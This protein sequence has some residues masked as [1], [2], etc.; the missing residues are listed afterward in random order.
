M[1][2]IKF[3]FC[4]VAFFGIY[5]LNAQSKKYAIHTV[6]FYNFENLFDIIDDPNTN[7]DEWTP[8]GA[9]H[10]T[11][12]KYEQKLKNLSRVLSEIGTPENSTAPTL[13]G[14][15]EIENRGVLEDLIKQ[16]KIA[17][18]DYGIIHFDSPDQRGIDVALLYQKKYFRPTSFS[19]IP[20]LI[21]KNKSVL[22]ENNNEDLGDVEVKIDIKNRVFT[23]DQ[24][25]VTGFLDDEE[26]HIIVNHWPSRSG[27]EKASSPYREAAGKLNRKI[28]D[29]LQQINPDAKVITMGDLN[30]GPF[31]KSVKMALG[32]KAKKAEVPEFGVYNPFEEMAGRGMGTLAFRDSWDIFDQIILTKSFIEPDFA[33]YEFWKAGIFNKPYL[34]QASGK[35]KGYPLRNSLT[36]AGFSDHFPVY[37]YLIREL[38]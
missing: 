10:W 25:L 34:I 19:N 29:S 23:R 21:Y 13:I 32:A 12:E 22:Q 9:Q 27:G 1:Q 31:N 5:I 37:I 4:L 6:A 16:E 30:D 38:K 20:L 26:I 35:Y 17:G 2:I 33:S 28:I 7:D 18:Y 11:K 3:H 15:S 36:E 24:L 14:C 8:T